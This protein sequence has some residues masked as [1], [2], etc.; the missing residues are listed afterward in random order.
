MKNKKA[1]QNKRDTTFVKYQTHA[2]IQGKQLH[3]LCEKKSK[4]K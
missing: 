2:T 1:M 3:N 4:K